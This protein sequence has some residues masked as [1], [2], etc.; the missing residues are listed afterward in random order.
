MRPTDYDRQDPALIARSS[1]IRR[2]LLGAMATGGSLMAGSRDP[3]W[4]PASQEWI[5]RNWDDVPLKAWAEARDQQETARVK[6]LH[7]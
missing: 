5:P 2:Q 4:E 1:P 6:G 7:L 3:A